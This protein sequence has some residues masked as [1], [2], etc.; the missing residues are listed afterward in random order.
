MV[1]EEGLALVKK[2]IFLFD[3]LESLAD[4]L[5]PQQDA[6]EANQAPEQQQVVKVTLSEQ[7]MNDYMEQLLKNDDAAQP[8]SQDQQA[9]QGHQGTLDLADA[10]S[11]E[12]VEG[13]KS[14]SSKAKKTKAKRK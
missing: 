11:Q 14:V 6:Q 1:D 4:A 13:K 12:G 5:L 7:A 9:Q 10:Q 8:A 2:G 3:S